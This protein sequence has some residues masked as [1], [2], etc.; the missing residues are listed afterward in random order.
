MT[1]KVIKRLNIPIN[2]RKKDRW[3]QCVQSVQKIGV[4]TNFYKKTRFEVF[5]YILKTFLWKGLFSGHSGHL[6]TLYP[7]S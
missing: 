6:I 4:S 1:L 5:L 7:F 3:I 2:P